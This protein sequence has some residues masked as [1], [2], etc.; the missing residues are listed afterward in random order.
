[1]EGRSGRNRKSGSTIIF[2]SFILASMLG[3]AIV[4]VLHA[5]TTAQTCYQRVV[6]ELACRSVLAEYDIR[7]QR[8]FGIYA[9]RGSSS[10]VRDTISNYLMRSEEKSSTMFSLT[11]RKWSADVKGFEISDIDQ[12][13]AQITAAAK[14]QFL[15][16]GKNFA[17]EK[18]LPADSKGTLSENENRRYGRAELKNEAIISALPSYGFTTKTFD[19]EI[20][21]LTAD[22]LSGLIAKTGKTFL[23]NSYA[24]SVFPCKNHPKSDRETY[25]DYEIEYL[26]AGLFSDAGNLDKIRDYLIRLRTPINIA[27]IYADPVQYQKALAEAELIA[28]G[29]GAAAAVLIIITKWAIEDSEK[30]AELL[31]SGGEADGLK[32]RDYLLIFLSLQDRETKLLR[33]M[34]LIQMDLRDGYY[35]DFL[36]KEHFCGFSFTAE[37]QEKRMLYVHTY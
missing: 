32:Y 22:G 33:M 23:V 19:P 8:D 18:F 4:F 29:A 28:P 7:L 6:D 3:T 14:Y 34:D 26:I 10:Y 17:G 12:F 2:L 5:R 37:D 35:T 25:L 15:N 11:G 27:K 16:L 20:P 31:I 21:D 13:E 1:M 9:F 24:L 36:L 30:E